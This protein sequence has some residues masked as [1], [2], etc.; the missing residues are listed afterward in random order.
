MIKA[1]TPVEKF[2]KSDLMGFLSCQKSAWLKKRKP[3]VISW[4]APSNFETL[5]SEDGYAVEAMVENYVSTIWENKFYQTQFEFETDDGLYARSD[6][7]KFQDSKTIELFEVKASTSLRKKDGRNPLLDAA[8]Q[9]FVARTSGYFVE[10][11]TIV[12]INKNY[13]RSGKVNPEEFLIFEDVTDKVFEILDGV[14]QDIFAMAEYL[15]KEEI[16]ADSCQCLSKPSRN[17]H[18]D[19]FDFFNREVPE[20]PVYWLPRLSKAKLKKFIENDTLSILD[21]SD[22]GLTNRQKKVFQAAREDV[23]QI[24]KKAIKSFFEELKWPLHFYDYET[25]AQAIP[26]SDGFKPFQQI[27]VQYSLHILDEDGTLKHFEFLSEDVGREDELI[28]SMKENFLEYGSVISW[29]KPFENTCNKNLASVHPEQ[30]SF[31]LEINARTVDLMDI[32]KEDYVDIKFQGSVSIKKVL[33]VLSPDLSYNEDV[34]HEGA[35][36]M[37]AFL[38]S[39]STTDVNKRNRLRSELKNYC[40]IDTLAMVKIFQR[41]SHIIAE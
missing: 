24:N 30:E 17:Q 32:F 34:V 11:V 12:L 38:E 6:I 22:S 3:D 26:V 16:E 13:V 19:S 15:S 8:F 1:T 4:P 35:G 36:A 39:I 27:P 21:I 31:L 2:I 40:E 28:S 20:I 18:C 33:P 9:T 14:E 23:P 41:I 5:L 29:N 7:V 10:R 37:A 25:V